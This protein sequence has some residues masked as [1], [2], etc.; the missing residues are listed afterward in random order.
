[1][2]IQ[3]VVFQNQKVSAEDHAALFEMFISDGLLS[4]CGINSL[5]NVLTISSGLFVHKGRLIKIVGSE[6]ITIP[7]SIVPSSGTKNIRLVGVVD[8]NQVSTKT[9][10][11]Q[12]RFRLGETSEELVKDDINTGTGRLYEVEWAILTIDTQGTITNTDIKIPSAA[13]SGGGSGGAGLPVFTFSGNSELIDDGNGNWRLKILSSGNLTFSNLGSG[14]SGVDV[15]LVGGGG[16]GSG[17]S[18]G[19]GGYVRTVSQYL[20]NRGTQYQLVVGN[21]GAGGKYDGPNPGNGDPTSAFGYSA[22]GGNG[23]S[24]NIGGSGGSGGASLNGGNNQNFTHAGFALGGSNGSNGAAAYGG[25]GGEGSGL[26]TREFGEPSGDLYAGG[27]CACSYTSASGNP[28][29]KSEGAPGSGVGGAS[30]YGGNGDSGNPT[31]AGENGAANTGNG[32]G[33][34]NTNSSAAGA[35]GS[36]IIIIRNHRTTSAA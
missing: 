30:G 13:A 7:D 21:G 32:G 15:F 18:G 31:T 16:G 36:G 27:G 33:G 2:A 11:N 3:G 23:A 34:G 29:Y 1:M 14:S 19:G 5:R 6:Q 9:E 10:F 4:G 22:N 8:L 25:S 12:F 24:L 26:T 28:Y 20:V 35:G 17:R